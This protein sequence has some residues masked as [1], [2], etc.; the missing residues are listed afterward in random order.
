MNE[1]NRVESLFLYV[2]NPFPIDFVGTF[3]EIYLP[4][5]SM[6]ILY[7]ILN[8]VNRTIILILDIDTFIIRYDFSCGIISLAW[9]DIYVPFIYVLFES[10]LFLHFELFFV[11]HEH[12]LKSEIKVS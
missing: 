3:L 10:I 9:R 12:V 1:L 5:E 2:F 8:S 4:Q 11:S 6:L 7:Q